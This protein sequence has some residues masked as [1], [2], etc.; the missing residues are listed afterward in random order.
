ML[1]SSFLDSH[2]D[3]VGGS[4]IIPRMHSAANA[5]AS[6]RQHSVIGMASVSSTRVVRSTRGAV[7]RAERRK[8]SSQSTR[9]ASTFIYSFTFL[10]LRD[11]S[12]LS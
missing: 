10:F 7:L 5:I 1:G 9:F 8:L 12:L 11:V 6:W 4:S 2:I 3:D